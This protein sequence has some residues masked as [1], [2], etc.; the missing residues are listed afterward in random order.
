MKTPGV[1]KTPGVCSLVSRNSIVDEANRSQPEV[2]SMIFHRGDGPD[3]IAR[4]PNMTRRS[5]LL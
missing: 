2:V 1:L 4:P 3:S 5:A